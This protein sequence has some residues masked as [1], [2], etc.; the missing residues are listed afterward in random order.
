[1]TYQ[2]EISVKMF[3]TFQSVMEWGSGKIDFIFGISIFNNLEWSK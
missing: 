3:A 2:L 1:M